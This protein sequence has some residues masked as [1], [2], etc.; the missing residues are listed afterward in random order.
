MLIR[1]CVKHHPQAQCTWQDA[2][3]AEMSCGLI[4]QF[5]DLAVQAV[6][7]KLDRTFNHKS[8]SSPNF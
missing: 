3:E 5:K 2:R 4:Y 1:G 6:S 8:F 7:Y